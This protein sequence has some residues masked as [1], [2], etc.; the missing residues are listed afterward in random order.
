MNEK[1]NDLLSKV[2]DDVSDHV[3]LF[4]QLVIRHHWHHFVVIFG[5]VEVSVL[6]LGQK[7]GHI[8]ENTNHK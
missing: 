1:S 6:P 4:L 8:L 7:V 3:T 2:L 5:Q